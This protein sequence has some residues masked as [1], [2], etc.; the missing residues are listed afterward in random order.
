MLPTGLLLGL[1]LGAT[2]ARGAPDVRGLVQ[3]ATSAPDLQRL[4]DAQAALEGGDGAGVRRALAG[5]AGPLTDYA[6]FLDAQGRAAAGDPVGAAKALERPAPAPGCLAAG[7]PDPRRGAPV[8]A[9]A[10]WLQATDPAAAAQLLAAEP[11]DGA[12]LARA[13]AAYR[14]ARRPEAAARAEET[15]LVAVPDHPEAAAL[16]A[17]LGAAGVAGRLTPERRL[18]RA[19][20]LLEAH[21][22]EA[23]GAEARALAA[24]LG[25]GHALACALGYVEGKALRKLRNYPA[26]LTALEAARK[27]CT[28]AKDMDTALRVALLE[29]Q[30]RG[31]RGQ[32]RGVK[33]VADWIRR[34]A[35]EHSYADDA[36]LV[37]AEVL[38]RKAGP[39]AARAAYGALLKAFPDGDQASTAAWRLALDALLGPEPEAAR[40]YLTQ[41]LKTQVPRPVEHAR[42]RYWLAQL[43]LAAGKEAEAKAGFEAIVLEPSF[44]GWLALDRLRAPAPAGRPEWVAAWQAR[45]RALRAQASTSAPA[46]AL[47]DA[48]P[49]VTRAAQLTAL[50]AL[51]WAEAELASVS[52]GGD[53]PRAQALAEAADRLGFHR[54]GQ[55]L[56]RAREAAWRHR[57]LVTDVTPWRLAYSRPY[58]A[59]VAAAA[60][61]GRVAPL[62]LWALAREESTF[63]PE[64]VS[65]AGAT[66][67]AQLMPATA[68]GAYAD[69]YGG[70]L[71][72]SRLTDPALNLRL[73][74]HVLGQGLRSFKNNE[75]LAL[76]AYNGGP[77]LA[78]RFIPDAPLRFDL[79]VETPTVRETRRYVKRVS[80][81]WAIYRW[82]YD[83]AEPFVRFPE[84][85]GG[86]AWR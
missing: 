42:A 60:R 17:E 81:T 58:A 85:M 19:R 12:R 52:C 21:V 65:W 4:R 36:L 59:E 2:P 84:T 79:W 56:L 83:E 20:N 75:A 26:A 13:V 51:E 9:R 67:L 23:A 38:A 11:P 80:E 57:G 7:S 32:A 1:V 76:A 54:A 16:A 43:D 28:Q 61:G 24:D 71:D 63:D 18:E 6:A 15:L 77:G 62:F 30:V 44:Y 64:I 78:R 53:L 72:M 49:A 68:V 35:P 10:A 86:P 25:P 34:V 47:G 22:N 48:A 29:V 39:D 40:P 66:G 8:E 14:A 50:G 70:K 37:E 45:L 46:A 55:M 31:I 41:L 74:A 82:L 5:Y 33:L 69:V 73:G 27:T 3:A